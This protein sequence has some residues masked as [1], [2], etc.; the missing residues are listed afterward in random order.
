[1]DPLDQLRSIIP[2]FPGYDDEDARQLTDEL[3]RSYLGEALARLTERF[4]SRESSGGRMDDL[5][6]RTG[7]TNQTAIKAYEERMRQHPDAAPM[8][9]ADLETVALADR[10]ENVTQAELADFLTNVAGV[11]DRRDAVMSGALLTS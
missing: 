6:L 2:N 7:F 9:A 8:A 3:V 4:E 1:M 5:L 11:L 10:A